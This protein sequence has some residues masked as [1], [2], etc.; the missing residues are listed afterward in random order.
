MEKKG[1]FYMRGQ[2]PTVARSNKKFRCIRTYR[3]SKKVLTY[4]SENNIANTEDTLELGPETPDLGGDLGAGKG[5]N[6]ARKK[7]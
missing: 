4:T 5:V 3:G 2:N 6:L 1:D 7:A